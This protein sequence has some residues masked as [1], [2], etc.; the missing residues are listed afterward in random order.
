MRLQELF[1]GMFELRE[2]L[3]PSEYRKYVKGWDKKKWA[4]LFN[5][6]Y[7]IYLP[8]KES[9]KII[10]TRDDYRDYA[11]DLHSINIRIGGKSEIVDGKKVKTGGEILTTIAGLNKYI[12]RIFKY[13]NNNGYQMVDYI[14]GYATKD[15]KNKKSIGSLL[16]S[17]PLLKQ[18][19]DNDPVR[20]GTKQ[21][22]RM[23]V[24]SRH[25]Y[26]IAGASTDR[27]WTSCQN[28]SDRMCKIGGDIKAGSLVAYLI[29]SNDK[30]INHPSARIMIKPF[31]D[32][33]E[34]ALGIQ[35]EIYGEKS[36]DFLDA[37]KQWVNT[38]NASR[39]LEGIFGLSSKVYNDGGRSIM[40]FNV[41]PS[42]I[43]DTFI[44]VCNFHT[45]S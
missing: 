40:F 34:I 36:K 28:L 21:S 27:G 38:I 6:K 29:N 14:G 1:E 22:N 9:P 20:S 24:I 43:I 19:F 33:K 4:E 7:R 11:S 8:L 3:K 26:D 13:L 2:A 42:E 41:K 31:T 25:P 35:D 30:N 12:Y 17:E 44:T 5:N 37:V 16:A 45:F 15:G 18:F 39:K 32:G 10:T 23:V